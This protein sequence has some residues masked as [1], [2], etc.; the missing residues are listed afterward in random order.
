MP[1]TRIMAAHKRRE[2]S[3]DMP[4]CGTLYKRF[5]IGFRRAGKLLKDQYGYRATTVLSS[6]VRLIECGA[7]GMCTRKHDCHLQ[8]PDDKEET[9]IICALDHCPCWAGHRA[10]KA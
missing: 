5:P 4:V 3:I 7:I 2:L 6:V 8:N 9:F 1:G 10:V